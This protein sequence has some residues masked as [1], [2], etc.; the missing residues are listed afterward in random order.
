MKLLACLLLFVLL[1]VS[2][3]VFS[4]S[5]DATISGGVTDPTGQF[6]TGAAVEVANDE[7]GVRY[8][9]QTN[10][11]GMYFVPILPPGRY[12]VQVSKQGFK[13]IIKSDV[14]LNV[15]GAIA[16][17]FVL[18]VGATSQSITVESGSSLLNT[19]DASV[20]TVIDRKFVENLPLN[21]RSFQDLISMTPGVVTQSPQSTQS[22]GYNGDFSVNGQRTESNYYTVDGV[23]G[24]FGAGNGYAVGQAAAG[25]AL[26]GSTALGT[27]QSLISVD[28]LQEFRVQSST[29]SA[30]YGR[31]PGGQFSFVTRSGT[32]ML[33]GSAFDYLRNSYFDANDWF[34]DH[35][36]TV[37][38]ALRQNDF[39]GTIGGPVWIPKVY[40]GEART[41]FFVSYEGLRLA[42]PQ[43]AALLY[44]PSTGLRQSGPAALQPILNAFPL[45]T[46]PEIQTGCTSG[47]TSTFPCLGGEPI[48]TPVPS[49]L[50]PFIK[51]YSLPARIDSTSVRLDHTFTSKVS[52]FFRYGD[53]PSTG[54]SR[55]LS[56]LTE[57]RFSARTYTVGATG[58]LSKTLSDE[59]R[60]G[61]A[62]ASSSIVNTLD[63]FG[64]GTPIN[65]AA[66]VGAANG[67]PNPHADWEIYFPGVNG[68]EIDTTHSN[69]MSDQWNAANNVAL[70]LGSHQLKVGIDYRRI[71]SPLNPATPLVEAL[72][73]T[74]PSV[75]ANQATEIDLENLISSQPVFNQTAVFV[76]DEWRIRPSLGLSFGLR[77]E[78]E[79]PPT[80]AHGNDAYTLLGSISNPS[81][82]Q[83]APRG[84]PLWKTGWFNLAPR[85][86]MAWQAR[87]NPGWETIVRAGG[88][89]FFD[90]NSQ[91]ATLGY[92][93]GIGFGAVRS[94]FGAPLPV[95]SAQLDFS[96]SAVSAPYGLIY[97]F[98]AHLQLPYTLEWNVSAQQAL[99]KPQTLTF[100]YVGSNGRR[101][102]GEQ[103]LS[104]TALNPKFGTVLYF[105]SNITSNYQALQV[106]FQRSVNRG[107]HALASYTWSHSLDFGS[108]GTSLPLTHGNSDFDV[109]NNFSGGLS[110]DIG[111]V[112]KGKL[113]EAIVS[114]WG[115]DGRLAARTSF[116]VTLLGSLK[117]DPATASYFHAGL[118]LVAGQPTYV[119]SAQLPG[120]RSINK[121]AFSVPTGTNI[122]NAPRNFARGFGET[123]INLAAR[124]EFALKES[125]KLQF[126]AEAFNVLNHPNF[127]FIDATYTDAMFGQATKMLN[128]SLATMASQYQQG[129]ARSMQFALK[130]LF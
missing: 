94:L 82:L 106:Q 53:T 26:G 16:L 93:N 18:P 126:R 33:H 9:V 30:E 114:Q 104:L 51:A 123:Q 23:S 108:T 113:L 84:T 27:T 36:G 50:S 45:P 22:L 87:T 52:V 47:A 130:L 40:K 90:T 101:L 17:N 92:T 63:A 19:T 35:Y 102:S 110:W 13:T 61:Y 20:S 41:F 70:S 115:L 118:N 6:I 64:G 72:Y 42:R 79:P 24:N 12:H 103:E 127:G 56:Q 3:A 109:R 32:N 48:G 96:P 46:G 105:P 124:R 73:E 57:A 43:A 89:V 54:D 91:I 14:V 5:T 44:V 76:Q 49:G 120:R 21:G 95:T 8:S 74:L 55:S 78:I 129:G 38:P 7:T 15:Q 29:Y 11:S 128:S 71:N 68:A 121:A 77:W 98:P 116:P 80:D 100:T 65:L 37:Q 111:D 85:L 59:F 62:R 10:S 83:L 122:G 81:S 28:A 125:L 4:Q 67:S 60:L 117:L 107:L 39:G 66:A 69:Q 112:R 99:G 75:L 1:F 86:G 58:Q 31:S 88:G 34:N 119:Y 97:A 2:P 25:G